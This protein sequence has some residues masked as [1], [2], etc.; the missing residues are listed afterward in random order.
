MSTKLKKYG[1]TFIKFSAVFLAMFG[2][3]YVSADYLIF[4]DT[5]IQSTTMSS[6]LMNAKMGKSLA[7]VNVQLEPVEIPN[8]PNE[9]AEVAA[10]ITLLKT[11]NN[12][13]TYQWLLPEG[14]E[15]VEGEKEGTLTS[16]TVEEPVLV[17]I[18]VTGY[19]RAEKKLLTLSASTLIGENAFSNVAVL[20]SRPQDS[21]D[22][23]AKQNFDAEKMQRLDLSSESPQSP[24]SEDKIQR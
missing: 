14:V 13:I 17:K 3:G 8:G 11:S 23:M 1:G 9:V 5:T 15:I 20:S 6:V 12:V 21:H 2:I 24:R 7:F 19:T 22:F 10:Y 16:V 4:P 18:K